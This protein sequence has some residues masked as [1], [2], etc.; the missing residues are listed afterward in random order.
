MSVE[1]LQQRVSYCA[2]EIEMTYHAMFVR[3]PADTTAAAPDQ[4]AVCDGSE[5]GEWLRKRD[6][7]R[8]G[9]EEVEER[10]EP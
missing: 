6:A 1:G 3:R 4:R 10:D 5:A 8:R 7:R 2:V 9:T